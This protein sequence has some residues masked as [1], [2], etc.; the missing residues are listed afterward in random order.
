M[1]LA[2]GAGARAVRGRISSARRGPVR[3]APTGSDRSEQARRGV[4]RCAPPAADPACPTHARRASREYVEPRHWVNGPRV[5]RH[6]QDRIDRCRHL[7]PHRP[8]LPGPVSVVNRYPRA[9]ESAKRHG[10]QSSRSLPVG[11]HPAVREQPRS[12]SSYAGVVSQRAALVSHAVGGAAPPF[13]H[14]VA[15]LHGALGD[16]GVLDALLAGDPSR[17]QRRKPPAHADAQPLESP[18]P[19]HRQRPRSGSMFHVKH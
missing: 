13:P 8:P 11:R 9:T 7:M 2:R 12:C 5:R 19:A 15:V 4:R 14:E 1:T 18:R 3:R 17:A 6:S 16:L 10:R